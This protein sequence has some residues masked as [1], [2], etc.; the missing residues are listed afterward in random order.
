AKAREPDAPLRALAAGIVLA[1]VVLYARVA[2]LI[3]LFDASLLEALWPRLLAL[4][5]VGVVFAAL[6]LRAED[7]GP[8]DA[9]KLRNPVELGK[10][11][12]LGILFALIVLLGRWAQATFGSTGLWASG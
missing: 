3:A 2:V 12:A 11:F 5:V 9:V 10:A 1:S 6:Q 7:G 4:L 8:A